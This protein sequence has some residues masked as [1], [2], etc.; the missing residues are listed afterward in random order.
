MGKAV[1]VAPE[2]AQTVEAVSFL[3]GHTLQKLQVQV[4]PKVARVAE[5][6]RKIL[7]VYLTA[8][9]LARHRARLLGVRPR[10][11]KR[12]PIGRFHGLTV[13]Q[14]LSALLAVGLSLAPEPLP[15]FAP[16]TRDE[17]RHPPPS[18]TALLIPVAIQP[19][20]GPN[21]T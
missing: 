19:T 2:V 12:W 10:D 21:A 7:R 17:E 5:A 9:T 15:S 14:V 18:P 1:R 6:M 8:T 20:A 11:L 3:C 16:R 13:A 4:A